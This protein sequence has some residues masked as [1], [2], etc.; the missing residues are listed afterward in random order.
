MSTVQPLWL[1]V[2]LFARAHRNP[3]TGI[4]LGERGVLG[5]R[6]GSGPDQ[7]WR[8]VRYAVQTG[9]LAEGSDTTRLAPVPVTCP[10]ESCHPA[11]HEL[12]THAPGVKP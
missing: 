8:A 2:V 11:Y 1:R 3:R 4:W 6:L 10:C 7:T 9:W 12:G 5:A